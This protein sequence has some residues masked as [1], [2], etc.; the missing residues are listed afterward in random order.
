MTVLGVV[1]FRKP[2]Q[3]RR[4]TPLRQPIAGKQVHRMGQPG[5]V[6]FPGGRPF[7]EPRRQFRIQ[8][9]RQAEIGMNRRAAAPACGVGVLQIGVAGGAGADGDEFHPVRRQP[10]G[11]RRRQQ[12]RDA[13]GDGGQLRLQGRQGAHRVELADYQRI[14]RQPV[15]PRLLPGDDA[16]DIGAG[17]GGKHRIA[18]AKDGAPG[19]EIRQMRHQF[20]RQLRRLQPIENHDDYGP[21]GRIHQQI[22]MGC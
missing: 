19:R 15:R 3:R 10:V 2:Q 17:Y 18:A 11:Q 12:R 1:G 6:G 22:T 7:P 13:A 4:R 8:R 14:G 5:A 20:R 9:A 21:G 16:G